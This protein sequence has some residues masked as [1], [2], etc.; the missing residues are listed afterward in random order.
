MI[1]EIKADTTGI[2]IFWESKPNLEQAKKMLEYIVSYYASYAESSRQGNSES[3]EKK[4]EFNSDKE[5]A[6]IVISALLDAGSLVKT[7]N[8][9]KIENIQ[10]GFESIC[11]ISNKILKRYN[12]KRSTPE[13]FSV[14]A[15]DIEKRNQ[16]HSGFQE[17]MKFITSQI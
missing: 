13:K 17:F 15:K 2:R 14:F 16:E 7:S 1:E 5:M 9:Y 11:E 3:L 4:G 12:N 8:G 6:G 10:A